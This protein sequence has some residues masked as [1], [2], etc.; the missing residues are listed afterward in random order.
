MSRSSDNSRVPEIA[1]RRPRGALPIWTLGV[2]AA[3][4]GCG[5]RDALVGM[6]AR[7]GDAGSSDLGTP[8][9]A[10][11][12]RSND[13]QWYEAVKLP[14]PAGVHFNSDALGTAT[15]DGKVVVLA[16]PG[17]ATQSD[18]SH[19]GSDAAVGIESSQLFKYGTFRADVLWTFCPSSEELASAATLY[20]TDGSDGNGNGLP[21]VHELDFQVLC[22][23]PSFIVLSAWSDYQKDADGRETF[24]KRSHAV[25]TATGDIYDTV[26]AGDASFAKTGHAAELMHPGFSTFG[27]FVDIGIA[28]QP[29]H[30]RFFAV[31]DG[32]E[33]TLWNL[34]DP[35]YIPQVPLTMIFNVWH[36]STHWL[37]N[38]TA[39]DIPSTTRAFTVDWAA[40]YPR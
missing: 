20:F 5:P 16:F 38:R 9:F 40:W 6:A 28:W 24:L 35:A 19:V 8:L 32:Q 7:A 12:M 34:T 21:D 4:V 29:D 33:T 31:L 39:A 15:H 10:S 30:V 25:D 1:S 11:E 37:P 22:G 18:A 23:N 36:P 14:S 3:L 27:A 26:A 2:A 17:D 13:G